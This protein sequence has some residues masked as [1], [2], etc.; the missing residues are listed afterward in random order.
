MRLGFRQCSSTKRADGRVRTGRGPHR[1]GGK[2]LRR[3]G[4]CPIREVELPPVI[5]IEVIHYLKHHSAPYRVLSHPHAETAQELA[6]SLHVS[7]HRVAK[8]VVIEADG[9]V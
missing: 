2:A 9:K 4:R 6:H 7:G 1:P 8:S 3:L 5:P